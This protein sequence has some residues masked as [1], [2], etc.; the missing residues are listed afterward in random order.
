MKTTKQKEDKAIISMQ[1]K[2]KELESQ[3]ATLLSHGVEL[4]ALIAAL[5]REDRI[6]PKRKL[7]LK[8]PYKKEVT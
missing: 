5:E 2:L 3:V 6:Q 1:T 4:S 7:A 8:P